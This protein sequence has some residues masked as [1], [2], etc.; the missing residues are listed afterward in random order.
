MQNPI[1]NSGAVSAAGCRF[2]RLH[3]L[4][5]VALFVVALIAVKLGG[6]D[7]KVAEA[8]FSLSTGKFPARDAHLTKVIFHDGGNL[9]IHVV[10]IGAAAVSLSGLVVRRL[11]PCS[12]AAIYVALCIGVTAG[13]AA[14]GKQLTNMDCPWSVTRFGGDRPY[15][16]LFS[17]RP[18]DLPRGG[19]FPGAHSSGAFAL[20]AFYFV[21]RRKNPR[22]ARAALACA[23]ALG[24]V[25]AAT[26]WARGAHFVSHDIWAAMLAWLVCLCC[27]AMF[28]R[29]L[30]PGENDAGESHSPAAMGGN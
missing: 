23:A 7:F 6:V 19:C 14:I 3:F 15:V 12:R 20:F 29:R 1:I 28:G 4:L 25:Y 26:Q 13:F 16:S 8:W 24:T 21:W 27:Y 10:A 30:W 11:R 18:D 17:D 22:R 5:P 9:L 2:W